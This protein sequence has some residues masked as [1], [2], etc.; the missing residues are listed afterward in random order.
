MSSNAVQK[1]KG[2]LNQAKDNMEIIANSL[3]Y[4]MALSE[5]LMK[6]EDPD[7]PMVVTF[8]EL[9]EIDFIIGNL[10][11]ADVIMQQSQKIS[12]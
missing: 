8:D 9:L 12:A 5:H 6:L 11:A 4:A 7:L 3:Y 1:Q 2:P 10:V